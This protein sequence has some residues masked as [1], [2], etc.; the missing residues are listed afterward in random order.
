MILLV[1]KEYIR[2]IFNKINI[3]NRFF[4]KF[5]ENWLSIINTI[6]YNLNNIILIEIKSIL[7]NKKKLIILLVLITNR[8]INIR[9]IE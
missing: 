4:K 7:N 9:I 8:S 5:D 6:I 1:E 2:V 3:K